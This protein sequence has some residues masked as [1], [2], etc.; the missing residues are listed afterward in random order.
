MVCRRLTHSAVQR[1]RLLLSLLAAHAL[2]VQCEDAALQRIPALRQLS[3]DP[4]LLKDRAESFSVQL[5]NGFPDGKIEVVECQ[6]RV[7]S[8]AAPIRD[9]PGAGL[10]I[11]LHQGDAKEWSAALR[12]GSP[13]VFARLQEE[14]LLL[15]MRTVDPSQETALLQALLTFLKPFA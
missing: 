8:G 12:M 10:T 5:R 6:G 14:K 11:Q 2:L 13:P 7:G 1:Q 4:G 3:W 15:D 9:L